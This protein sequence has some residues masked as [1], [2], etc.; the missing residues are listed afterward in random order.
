VAKDKVVGPWIHIDF[1]EISLDEFDIVETCVFDTLPR[2]REFGSREVNPGEVDFRIAGRLISNVASTG[3]TQVKNPQTFW[4]IGP[5]PEQT[6]ESQ[7]PTDF[8]VCEDL[9]TV[10]RMV[11]ASAG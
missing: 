9:I 11:V 4:A 10:W 8:K 7:E 3:T 2:D 5:E 1:Q 6:S